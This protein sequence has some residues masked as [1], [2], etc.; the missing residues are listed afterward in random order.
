[1]HRDPALKTR[2]EIPVRM[3]PIG[4]IDATTVAAIVVADAGV[5]FLAALT[6]PG[7]V[8]HAPKSMLPRK[9]NA[10]VTNRFVRV[11]SIFVPLPDNYSTAGSGISLTK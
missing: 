6:K 3:N 2:I 9:I 7:K 1:M 10:G 11:S 8:C 5:R 4:N